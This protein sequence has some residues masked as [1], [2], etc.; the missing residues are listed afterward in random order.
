VPAHSPILLSPL[1]WQ[2]AHNSKNTMAISHHGDTGVEPMSLRIGYMG[3]DQGG[4]EM[5]EGAR[6]GLEWT[7]ASGLPCGSR[8]ETELLMGL[9]GRR[10]GRKSIACIL[11]EVNGRAE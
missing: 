1:V 3:A 4:T 9:F 8:T 10:T 6:L 7:R 11:L 5:L 2:K